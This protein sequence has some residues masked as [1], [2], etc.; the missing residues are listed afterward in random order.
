[1]EKDKEGNSLC[2][3]LFL[4]LLL[5]LC[6]VSC[7]PLLI[8]QA[9][10]QGA[11]LT[12]T[13][14][15]GALTEEDNKKLK[16]SVR[17]FNQAFGFQDYKQA[18]VFVSPEKKEVFWS[19]VDRFTGEIRIAG[20]ELRDVQ[21]DEKT[22]QATVVLSLQYW[23]MKSPYLKT[24]SFTQRWQYSEKQWK[25]LDMGFEAIPQSSH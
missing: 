23:L 10:Y 11:M 5:L 4:I 20:C 22:K 7:T 19:E 21:I 24:V 9:A 14:V 15:T 1:M 25:I 16:E 18:S 2:L 13:V 3:L 8:G 17:A 12:N 6:G